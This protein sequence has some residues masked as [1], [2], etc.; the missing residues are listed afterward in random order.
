MK[1]PLTLLSFGLVVSAL[2]LVSQSASAQAFG[3]KGD[4]AFSADRMFAIHGTHTFQENP[5]PDQPDQ[6][7]DYTG[8]TFL[9]RG[10]SAAGPFD[11]PRLAFDYF[12]IDRLSV[13][14][15]I[16][17]A[18]LKGE[19]ANNNNA[20]GSQSSLLFAPRVG[21]AF[22]FS[23]VVGIWPRGAITYHSA[24]TEFGDAESSESGL[25]LTIEVPLVLSPTPHL[26]FTVG[27]T[28]DMDLFGTLD[29]P[30]GNDLD[31]TY[32]TFGL[33]IGMFGWL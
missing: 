15:T 31:R 7:I 16:G 17:Y 20:N 32:R 28:F 9:W 23:E 2:N 14:G 26:G 29:P 3:A 11:V 19:D 24:S 18:S 4:A 25:A 12:V 21:Y 1:K 33:Q 27:P 30:T 8:I 5:I 6:E 10:T 22:M 13:G